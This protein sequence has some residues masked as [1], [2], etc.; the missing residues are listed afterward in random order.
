MSHE[1]RVKLL[2]EIEEIRSTIEELQPEVHQQER[3][4]GRGSDWTRT[5]LAALRKELARDME[6]LHAG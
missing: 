1:E 6:Q 3:S 5:Q 2:R 4:L